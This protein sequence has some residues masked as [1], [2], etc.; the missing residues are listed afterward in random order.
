MREKRKKKGKT[1]GHTGHGKSVGSK[2]TLHR[3]RQAPGSSIGPGA[4][5]RDSGRSVPW[6]IGSGSQAP[7]HREA[8]REIVDR[9]EGNPS[10]VIAM[11]QDLQEAFGYLPEG[12]LR[13]LAEALGLPLNRIFHIATF[14]KAFRLMPRGRHEIKL[15]TG[16]ACHVR[17]VE[18][19]RDAITR[20]LG[21]REGETTADLRFSF[22]T[23]HCLG[24]CGLAPVMMIDNDIHGKVGYSVK[25]ILEKYR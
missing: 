24:C 4:A 19:V 17:G 20:E 7:M 14:Y 6:R 18:A 13:L 8:V 11:M 10:R 25:E 12:D 9:Y 23:V 5:M 3:L 16:T 22:E 21:I 15:C 2:R 1:K